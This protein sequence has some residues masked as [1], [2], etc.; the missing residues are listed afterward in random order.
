VVVNALKMRE[1]QLQRTEEAMKGS[2]ERVT[3][4]EAELRDNAE[5][6]QRRIQELVSSLERERLDHEVTEGALES[7]RRERDQ[8]QSDML[9]LQMQLNRLA[10]NDDDNVKF[11]TQGA[12]A[13]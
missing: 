10:V 5:A 1:T 2:N 7:T 12:N 4:L 11:P 3:R 6:F 8:L 9:Q 13:A